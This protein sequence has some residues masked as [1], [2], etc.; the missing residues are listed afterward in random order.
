VQIPAAETS[1]NMAQRRNTSITLKQ[2]AQHAGVSVSAVSAVLNN[3]VSS[4]RVSD[5]TASQIRKAALELN[6]IPNGIA[7]SLRTNRTNNVGLVFENFG[8][9]TDGQFYVELLNGVVQELFKNKYRLT[10]LPEVDRS[11]PLKSLGNGILDGIIWCK[12]PQSPEVIEILQKASMPFVA[13]HARPSLGHE[14]AAYIT[15]DNYGGARLAVQHLHELGHKH[16]LFVLEEFEV[17]VPD[18]Q[19]RLSG[20]IDA[21]TEFGI[22]CEEGDIRTWSREFNE[23][24]DYLSSK[25]PHTAIICWNERT[26]A[27]LLDLAIPAGINVPNDLSV[28][29]FDSTSYSER[30]TPRLTCVHQPIGE[31][32]ATAARTLLDHLNGIETLQDHDFKT[33]L[34]IRDSTTSAPTVAPWQHSLKVEKQQ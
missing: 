17:D 18:A 6:Y 2:V 15:S 11:N 12:L 24:N 5:E 1:K 9:I 23:F 13:L 7:Q 8:D 31:M 10:I 30:T 16:I 32:G 29:G 28:I 14:A 4:I 21:C 27:L 20:F 19:A 25:P 33:H 34:D 26:A 22:P 3:K